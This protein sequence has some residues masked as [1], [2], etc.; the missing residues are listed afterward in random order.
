MFRGSVLES[1]EDSRSGG[2]SVAISGTFRW[3]DSFT[4]MVKE[5]S[6]SQ[7]ITSGA[8]MFDQ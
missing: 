4:G 3:A 2:G 6:G 8:K 7:C 1:H 5:K